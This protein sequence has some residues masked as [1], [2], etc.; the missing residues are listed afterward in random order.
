MAV[1]NKETQKRLK[2]I[3]G[4]T[5]TATVDQLYKETQI[6]QADILAAFVLWHDSGEGELDI[7]FYHEHAQGPPELI[8]RRSFIEGMLKGQKLCLGC[9]KNVDMKDLVCDFAF[10]LSIGGDN[11][12]EGELESVSL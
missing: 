4:R 10:T 5:G 11:L 9:N 1:L 3:V 2:K 8:E 6:P 12:E 7:L